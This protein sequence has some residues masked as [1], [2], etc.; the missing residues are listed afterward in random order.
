MYEELVIYKDIKNNTCPFCGSKNL[1]SNNIEWETLFINCPICGR[2][3]INIYDLKKIDA[4]KDIISSIL[5]HSEKSDTRILGDENFFSE[6]AKNFARPKFIPIADIHN[7]Y[8]S[9]FSTRIENLLLDIAKHSLYFGEKICY[10]IEEFCSA[11]Y[12]KRFDEYGN[13]LESEKVFLQIK[14]LQNFINSEQVQYVKCNQFESSDT[15]IDIE[16]LPAGWQRVE[17]LEI[18]EKNNKKVFIAMAF[19]KETD[20][21]REALKLGITHAGYEPILIDELTHNHQIVPEMF[22]KIRESKFLVID[23]SI[24]N[25]GAYYEAGYAHGL[26]K[27]VIFCCKDTSFYSHEKNMRPHFD[28]SQKQMIIWEDEND[29]SKKLEK[30]IYSLFKK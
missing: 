10:E 8:P 17:N 25:T 29:L 14:K 12:I 20:D 13:K 7:F 18:E 21:T 23:I 27:E 24:P 22:N 16:L 28:I 26:G 2:C 3:V 15:F 30:W 6:N 19:G 11:A 1:K 9:K 4:Q 5:Y